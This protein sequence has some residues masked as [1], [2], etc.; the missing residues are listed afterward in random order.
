MLFN[1]KEF[2]HPIF[3]TAVLKSNNLKRPISVFKTKDDQIITLDIHMDQKDPCFTVDISRANN[4]ISLK[5]TFFLYFKT[6]KCKIHLFGH[7]RSSTGDYWHNF[8]QDVGEREIQGHSHAADPNWLSSQLQRINEWLENSE[9]VR[10]NPYH[11][12]Q[13]LAGE[14]TEIDQYLGS[15]TTAL[16]KLDINMSITSLKPGINKLPEDGPIS[17]N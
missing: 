14:E 2:R 11:H 8:I 7:V 3:R 13:V 5:E 4:E 1:N 9:T 10:V 17:L 6:E 15:V 12:D 16:D